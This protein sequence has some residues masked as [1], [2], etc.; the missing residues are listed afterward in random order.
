MTAPVTP[1]MNQTGMN[2]EPGPS[3]AMI[4][5]T[6]LFPPSSPGDEL[7]IAAVREQY[8]AEGEPIGS[9]P[10][11][12]TPKGM[13]E[14]A[15]GLIKAQQPLILM[16]KLG[17]RLAFERSGTRLYQAFLGKV[18]AER[19]PQ[20]VIA[21]EEVQRALE[22]EAQHFMLVHHA[23][24]QLGGD[25]TAVT[26]SADIIGVASMGLVQVVSDPRTTVDQC[27]CAM[28]TAELVDNDGW[29]LLI[30]L[31]ESLG[32]RELATQ[33]STALQNEERHL[34][35]VRNWVSTLTM[36]QAGAD[37]R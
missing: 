32:H 35:T 26:P 11:P 16:D 25:P 33:F 8:M 37:R 28:L 15:K 7:Q 18:V 29:P 13:V 36:E 20:R 21:V 14:S 1:R 27:L 31:A 3:K 9:I 12:L 6:S 23:I 2:L 24:E 19:A 17:E 22:E 5:A 30:K 10:L 4:E 34:M